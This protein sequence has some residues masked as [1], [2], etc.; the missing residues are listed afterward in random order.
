[1][2]ITF[3]KRLKELREDHNLSQTSLANNIKAT[4]SAISAWETGLRQ[5]TLPY[6]IALAK[7]FDVTLDYL[8]GLTEY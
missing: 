3:G 1:M 6:L 7:F 8:A 2:Q 5:P 4:H